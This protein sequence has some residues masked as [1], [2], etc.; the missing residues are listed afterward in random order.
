MIVPLFWCIVALPATG[1]ALPSYWRPATGPSLSS[2]TLHFPGRGD[3]RVTLPAESTARVDQWGK[4]AE[5]VTLEVD[6]HVPR[7]PITA[8][9]TTSPTTRPAAY[10]LWLTLEPSNAE[11]DADLAALHRAMTKSAAQAAGASPTLIELRGPAVEGYYYTSMT[12]GKNGGPRVASTYGR[13]LVGGICI[14][15][16]LIHSPNGGRTVEHALSVVR[17]IRQ[18]P[19]STTGPTSAPTST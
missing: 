11:E 5:H 2:H 6:W 9:A 1:P 19:R 16:S 18:A 14:T 10:D 3:L 13:V 15:F 17:G 12:V 8:R 7:V 4:N